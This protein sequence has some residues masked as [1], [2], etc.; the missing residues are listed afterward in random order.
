[1]RINALSVANL[2]I[3]LS[4]RD[5]KPI[6]QLSLMKMVYISHG[7]S[8]ALINLSLL[9][10]RFDVVEA[11]KF[12]PVIPSVYHS[13]KCYRDKQIT[14]RTI[15]VELDN[16]G[17]EI[18]VEPDLNDNRARTIVE[19]V[20]NRYNKYSES[21]LVN[22]THKPGTPWALCYE[23]S[24]NKEIPDSFTKLYYERLVSNIVK[25]STER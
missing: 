15:V 6:T 16:Y 14:H 20:W 1:M 7:F 23:E 17:R 13:F 3:D 11:W 22:L 9:D 2:L 5:D 4:L 18:Y 21:E 24:L 8:L 10:P 25:D 12:G 19:M